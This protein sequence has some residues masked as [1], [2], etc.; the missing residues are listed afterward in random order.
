[1][2]PRSGQGGNVLSGLAIARIA[3]NVGIPKKDQL[4]GPLRA[5]YQTLVAF[6]GLIDAD[7]RQSIQNN[8]ENAQSQIKDLN[9]IS[10]KAS[11]DG[12]NFEL[13]QQQRYAQESAKGLK[14]A[15][16]KASKTMKKTMTRVKGPGSNLFKIDA[17]I[18]KKLH[19]GV[20]KNKSLYIKLRKYA[21]NY[22]DLTRPEQER[23]R[24]NL[25]QRLD[26][27]EKLLRQYKEE[28]ILLEQIGAVAGMSDKDKVTLQKQYTKIA[29]EK[30]YIEAIKEMIKW[31]KKADDATARGTAHRKR[32]IAGLEKQIREWK[33]EMKAA[34]QAGEEWAEQIVTK[35]SYRIEQFKD[36]LMES[37][38]VLTAFYY[39]I[40]EIVGSLMSF[41]QELQNAQSIFQTTYEVLFSLSDE[42]V[43]FGTQFGVSYDNAAKGLY[44][45]ASAGL[46]AEDSLRVLND[47]LRLSMAVQGD[48]NTLSKLT[49]QIIYGFG[50]EM[51]DATD[52]TDKL[53]YAIN[54][55]LIEWQD[56]ASSVKFALPFFISAGQNLEQ[57]LGALEILTNRALEAGIAGRGLRQALAE[58]TQH[59]KDNEAAFHKLGVEIL[60][61]DGNM[62]ELTD[63]ALQF[64]AALGED[65]T[66]MEVMIALMEDLNVR[67]ATAFIHLAL[68][69]REYAAAVDDLK[70]STGAAHKMAMIQQMGLEA[71]LQRMKNRFEAAFLFSD[72]ATTAAGQM[73][74]LTLAVS[75][76]IEELSN[77]IIIG[78]GAKAQLT[79]LGVWLKNVVIGAIIEFT[80]LLKNVIKVIQEWSE[81]GLFNISVL[82]LY[83]LPLTIVIKLVDILGPSI[84]KLVITMYVLH[85]TIGITTI[86]W[87]FFKVALGLTTT[88]L[89][90]AGWQMVKTTWIGMWMS[91]QVMKVWTPVWGF[92][93]NTIWGV[94]AALAAVVAGFI[95]FY[96]VGDYL[97]TNLTGIASA[98]AVL[99]V[100]IALVSVAI[101]GIKGAIAAGSILAGWKGILGFAAAAGAVGLGV[102][103]A[104]GWLF[105]S[106][107]N[108]IEAEGLEAY[109]VQ[110]E[111][112][113]ST[114]NALGGGATDLYVD[115]LITANDDLGERA[116]ASGYTDT[117]GMPTTSF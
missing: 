26:L 63:I 54:K 108:A 27:K 6:R 21:K 29:K 3:V 49:T 90:W 113:V 56:L 107:D 109:M 55:S 72:E 86:A 97:T 80:K 46:S 104:K 53:A 52:V 23:M 71:S 91:K 18:Q 81:A 45:F 111:D 93:G 79:D 96:K 64:N 61:T 11:R 40:N 19:A 30:E 66:T 16:D 41:Q 32:A 94:A 82:K 98:L 69:A 83:F 28:A 87:F 84:G 101:Y 50:L 105:K 22:Y 65:A 24:V 15:Q 25:Q 35:L 106:G 47:T 48:H 2:P 88:A 51:A 43:E 42:V 117:R 37:V 59:A 68:N 10:S 60:D 92:F 67:G 17:D 7:S 115:N 110:L 114:N 4:E 62:R 89:A 78:E 58:F 5:I 76:V 74:T 95:I 12:T 102:G 36:I 77:L 100:M 14:E 39:K 13:K 34:I 73:N 31:Q 116:Y 38:I 70:N 20:E 8:I 9:D 99:A 75:Y 103:A 44:Q 1:M 85:K 112:R 33:D 57:L